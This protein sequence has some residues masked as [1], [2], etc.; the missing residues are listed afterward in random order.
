M[1]RARCMQKVYSNRTKILKSIKSLW[2]LRK[3]G[4]RVEMKKKKRNP[5]VLIN[6]IFILIIIVAFSLIFMVLNSS[7]DKM[8][9]SQEEFY[10]NTV[11]VTL[12]TRVVGDLGRQKELRV[13]CTSEECRTFFDER[14]NQSLESLDQVTLFS[15]G[16][17]GR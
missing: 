2:R 7:V 1:G 13:L 15:C 10:C 5:E 3:G 11:K 16:R 17:G 8:M 4:R 12:S 14:I 9:E 6:C